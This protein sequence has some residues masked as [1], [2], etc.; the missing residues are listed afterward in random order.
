[1]YC[2]GASLDLS[3]GSVMGLGGAICGLCLVNQVPI[4]LAI[5][6]GLL[7]SGLV[8]MLNALLIVNLQIPALIA[9]LGTMY[10]ARG[11]VNVLTKGEPYYPL[12]D[13][14]K[15]LGQGTLAGIPYSVFLAL[16]IVAVSHFIIK[17]PV[18]GEA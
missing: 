13:A 7:V 6:A 12:P 11:V 16:V 17:R 10:I 15:A 2:W 5:G 4:P 8:G 9:T 1:M 14:F 3:I 18:T